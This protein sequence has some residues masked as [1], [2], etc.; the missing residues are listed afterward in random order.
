MWAVGIIV[1]F[2]IVIVVAS[3]YHLLPAFRAAPL[4][5]RLLSASG[6]PLGIGGV[7]FII[8]FWEPVA[9]PYRANVLYPFGDHLHAWAVSFG[10]TWLAYGLLFTGLALLGARQAS[11]IIWATLLASWFICWLP[12]GVIGV[13]F[14]WAGSNAP[15]VASYRQWAAAPSGMALLLF[16]AITLL[17][18][19]GLGLA[20]FI[21]TAIELRRNPQ[22]G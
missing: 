10:F 8:R 19:W 11:R 14:A 16:N 17:A 4:S 15:S 12:H 7:N 5:W 3:F 2:V 9:G 22:K 18:H 13:A 6:I 20:G 21:M 1:S